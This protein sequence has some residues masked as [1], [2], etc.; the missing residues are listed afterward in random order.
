MVRPFGKVDNCQAGVFAAYA[1][2][3]VSLLDRRLYLPANGSMPRTASAGSGVGY[4]DTP[5]T[6]KPALALE[7]LG[8]W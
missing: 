5:F 8:R 1:S 4:P 7:M 3:R 2:R 6:T